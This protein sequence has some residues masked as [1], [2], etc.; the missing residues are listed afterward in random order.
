LVVLVSTAVFLF[1][2]TLHVEPSAADNSNIISVLQPL[3]ELT[4]LLLMTFLALQLQ[5]M[6][7]PFLVMEFLL[8]N[9]L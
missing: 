1:V 7:A 8:A 4:P 3:V 6:L 5:S 9:P 2:F